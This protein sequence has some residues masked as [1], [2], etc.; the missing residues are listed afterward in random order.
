MRHKNE[1]LHAN[2]RTLKANQTVTLIM[3]NSFCEKRYLKKHYD[4]TATTK[5]HSE[6]NDYKN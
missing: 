4:E 2:S 1:A 3:F 5:Q 6:Q